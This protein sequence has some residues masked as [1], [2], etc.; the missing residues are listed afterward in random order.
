MARHAFFFTGDRVLQVANASDAGL[1]YQ[2][3]VH[4]ILPQ[5]TCGPF[6]HET[7]ETVI[8]VQ[9]GVLELMVN[10]VAGHLA[11][12]AF[13]R[14]PAGAWFGYRNSGDEPA[15]ILSRTAPPQVKRAGYRISIQLTAA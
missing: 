6:R 3:Q 4:S 9:Q 2:A 10:G 14:I 15:H 7:A 12:G 11:T 5:A 1:S 13:A 8:V